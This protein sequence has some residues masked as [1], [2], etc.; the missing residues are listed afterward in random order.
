M[1]YLLKQSQTAQPLLFL[2]VDSADHV[3]AKTGLSPTVTIS[4]NGASFGSPSGT[5]SEVGS[6]WYKVAGN[7]TDTNTLGPLLLHATASGADPSDDRF[8][9]VAFDPQVATNLGL[10]ALPTANPGAANGV[11]I[12]GSNA[13][14]SVTTALTANIT[15]N[16]SGSVNSVT[17]GVTLAADQAVN[18]TKVDGAAL[19]THGSGY[20]PGDV[21]QIVGAAVSTS[22]AQ[23]G[24]NTVQAGG[25]AWG[26]GAITAGAIATNAIDADA[27][28]DNAI[29]AAAI[30]NG[31][32]TSIKFADDFLTASKVADGAIDANTFAAGA[33]TANAIAADAIGASEL[34]ADAATE[35]GTAVWATATR[36]L[37]SSQ[38]FNL[39]GDITGNLS[40]SVGSV[41]GNVGGNVTGS[42]GSVASGGIT[43][44]S[45][46][47]GAIDA[48][49]LA[50]DAVN[51]IADGL[52]DRNMA[53]GSDSGSPTVRTVRQALRL[54][55]NKWAVST[56]T[57]TVYKEDD[58]TASWTGTA[59][60]DAAAD[61][62]VSLDPAS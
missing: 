56:G 19:S 5:V 48:D 18:V 1:G 23:L 20:F 2:M 15:G 6:G 51:E 52:L 40:G 58:T 28:A 57:L 10:S 39:T 8:D 47:T 55:R 7:A 24:V 26:S 3:S 30:A 31:A 21:R 62:V 43:A 12:A 34:A 13:A 45:I 4:K 50:T 29:D 41:T 25:T 44:A 22:T 27:I 14:T 33:I 37:T 9:I 46:A 60:T 36:Q 17:T 42:V 59:G 61:P 35:I 32:L 11:F 53:T 54:L 49:A 38:T 16:L